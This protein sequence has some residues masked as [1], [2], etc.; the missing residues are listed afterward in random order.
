M[1]L[2]SLVRGMLCRPTES[3]KSIPVSE[4]VDKIRLKTRRNEK[5]LDRKS[6]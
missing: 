6:V 1:A 4:I 3:V 2:S 5:I